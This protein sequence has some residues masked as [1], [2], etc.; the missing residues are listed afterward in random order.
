MNYNSTTEL[1]N[2]GV[3]GWLTGALASALINGLLILLVQRL[4]LLTKAGWF[5]AWCLGT[6]L[7]ASIGWRGWGAVVLYLAL[8]SAVTKLGFAK[9]ESLG[10]AEARGGRRG[11]ENVWGSAATGALLALATLLPGAPKQL[12]LSGF[13]AS[14]AAKLG[15]TFGSEIGK[16][17][18]RSTVSLSQWKPVPPGTDGAVSLEGTLASLAGSLLFSAVGWALKLIPAGQIP[19]I[20]AVAFFACLIESLIGAELQPRVSWLSNEAVNGLLTVIAAGLAMVL[21]H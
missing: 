3:G 14:F 7:A 11:P 6:L 19:L 5:H 15:D 12:L 13:V 21:L 2:Q 8:G 16:R 20:T 9:K 1:I 4:P 10:I 17:W 18:G